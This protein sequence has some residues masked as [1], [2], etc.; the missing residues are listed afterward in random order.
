MQQLH[1]FPNGSE[2]NIKQSTGET[3]VGHRVAT[4]CPCLPWLFVREPNA[5]V[6][7]VVHVPDEVST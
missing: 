3:H 4:D 5:D 2:V 6:L 7:K 1:I